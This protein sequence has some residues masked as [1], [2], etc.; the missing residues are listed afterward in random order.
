MPAEQSVNGS[1]LEGGSLE[2]ETDDRQWSLEVLCGLADRF[3]QASRGLA[4]RGGEGHPDTR[5]TGG[6]QGQQ[7]CRCG[8]FSGAWSAGHEGDGPTETKHRC[9]P[10]GGVGVRKEL[11]EI[12]TFLWHVRLRLDVA[13]VFNAN[14]LVC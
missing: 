7:S 13:S 14:L 11:S 2:P 8:G 10:L 12:G 5:L 4:G 1:G 3:S 6:E 9:A